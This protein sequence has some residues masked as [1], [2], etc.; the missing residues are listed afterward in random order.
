MNFLHPEFLWLAPLLA[1][2]IL[3][4]LLN[5]VRYRRMRWAAIE[6]LL[7]TERRAVRRARL[8]QPIRDGG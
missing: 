7:Q 5:R 8:R 6:F 1:V 2:P 3:I 4:H